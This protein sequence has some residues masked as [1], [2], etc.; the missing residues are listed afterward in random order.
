MLDVAITSSSFSDTAL[1][2][3]PFY[4]AESTNPYP[5]NDDRE[6]V[7]QLDVA[8]FSPSGFFSLPAEDLSEPVASTSASIVELDS[9][10]G[11]SSLPAKCKRSCCSSKQAIM[12]APMGRWD[13]N[14]MVDIYESDIKGEIAEAAGLNF[15]DMRQVISSTAPS[16]SGSH[17]S[18]FDAVLL[19]AQ[20]YLH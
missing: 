20:L 16:Q 9:N 11:S 10:A 15:I 5:L 7:N 6:L 4:K 17:W 19:P 18:L 14:D 12:S 13:S 8:Y 2:C 1:I 3:S